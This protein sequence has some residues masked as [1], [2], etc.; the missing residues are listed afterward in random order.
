MQR[1][2]RFSL[3][4][5]ITLSGP[6]QH[7]VTRDNMFNSTQKGKY[8]SSNIEEMKYDISPKVADSFFQ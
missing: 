8:S 1:Q 7:L 5:L 3:H 2:E 4:P 6:L